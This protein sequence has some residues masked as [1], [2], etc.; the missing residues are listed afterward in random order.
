MRPVFLLEHKKEKQQWTLQSLL[1][2]GNKEGIN[3]DKIMCLQIV[4]GDVIAFDRMWN[5]YLPSEIWDIYSI[6]LA[7]QEMTIRNSKTE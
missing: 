4:D 2:T 1:D 5:E 3:W 6:K 7:M